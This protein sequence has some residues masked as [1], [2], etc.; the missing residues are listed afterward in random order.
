MLEHNF[1]GV[2]VSISTFCEIQG[3][4]ST[5][6]ELEIVLVIKIIMAFVL[7]NLVIIGMRHLQ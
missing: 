1:L 2:W 4:Q 7:L 3:N 6:C 5:F